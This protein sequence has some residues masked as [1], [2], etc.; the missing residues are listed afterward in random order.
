MEL[1]DV[2]QNPI[3]I[4]TCYNHRELLVATLRALTGETYD[5]EDLSWVEELMDFQSD[6]AKHW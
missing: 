3:S 1:R 6:G 5:K 2:C 4:L